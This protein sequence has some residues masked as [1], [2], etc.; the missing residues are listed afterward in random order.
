MG[1]GNPVKVFV[2]TAKNAVNE[3]KKVGKK[4]EKVVSKAGKQLEQNVSNGAQKVLGENGYNVAKGALTA[5]NIPYMATTAVVDTVKG[6]NP[7]KGQI[8]RQA[9]AINNLQG[10]STPK[11][12]PA[13]TYDDTPEGLDLY[14][15][16]LRWKR[17][18]REKL[19]MNAETREKTNV[20]GGSETLGV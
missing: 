17:R 9:E 12:E 3:V 10:K 15:A 5:L 4:A 13:P 16:N 7:L 6:E 11:A 14:Q 19:S 8:Q 1:G 20:L 18:R 2:D